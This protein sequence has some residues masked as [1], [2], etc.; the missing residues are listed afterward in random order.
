MIYDRVQVSGKR[1]AGKCS[2]V[3]LVTVTP[4]PQ[5]SGFQALQQQRR[6]SGGTRIVGVPGLC[7]RDPWMKTDQETSQ[8]GADEADASPGRSRRGRSPPG[9]SRRR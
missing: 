5:R 1:D 8:G 3:Q 9:L 2:T 4:P 6:S 7:D